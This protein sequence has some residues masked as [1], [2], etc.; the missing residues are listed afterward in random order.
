MKEWGFV[1]HGIK[2]TKNGDEVVLTRPFGK[3]LPIDIKKPK[4]SFPFF[5]RVYAIRE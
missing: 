2:S 3:S 1:E 5:S 4:H